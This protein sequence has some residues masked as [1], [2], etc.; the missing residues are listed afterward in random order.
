MLLS[1][2]K[3]NKNTKKKKKKNNEQ[4]TL[5][6]E[7]AEEAILRELLGD[8]PDA[9]PRPTRNSLQP[10][11]TPAPIQQTP[12]RMAGFINHGNSCFISAAITIIREMPGICDALENVGTSPWAGVILSAVRTSASG[13]KTDT[14]KLHSLLCD[15]FPLGEQADMFEF[16]EIVLSLAF[17]G[18]VCPLMRSSMKNTVSCLDAGCAQNVSLPPV[19]QWTVKIHIPPA[20]AQ[21]QAVELLG[22]IVDRVEGVEWTC[23]AC[24]AITGLS[25]DHLEIPPQYLALHLVRSLTGVEQRTR[26]HVAKKISIREKQYD[27]RAATYFTGRTPTRGHYVVSI[28]AVT[29]EEWLQNDDSLFPVDS[30]LSIYQGTREEMVMGLLYVAGNTAGGGKEGTEW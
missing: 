7:T 28:H 16:L 12:P 15:R 21:V 25:A 6:P 13:V 26:V 18:D 19:D 30:G 17:G 24:G 29:G 10:H 9:R 20:E 22:A 14:T 2:H 3:K 1:H 8:S 23:M 4:M 5:K 11:P 27:L